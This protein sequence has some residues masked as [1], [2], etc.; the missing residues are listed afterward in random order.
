MGKWRKKG[1][2]MMMLNN[3]Y[4]KEEMG[5]EETFVREGWMWGWAMISL[6]VVVA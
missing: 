5:Y 3:S 6:R 2:T 1:F 4:S